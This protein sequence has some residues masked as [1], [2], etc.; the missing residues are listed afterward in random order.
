MSCKNT[1]K[2]QRHIMGNNVTISNNAL[3]IKLSDSQTFWYP[4]MRSTQVLTKVLA[5]YAKENVHKYPCNIIALKAIN[6]VFF[7]LFSFIFIC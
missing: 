2:V 1:L 7:S 3:N 5:R 6:W 4:E